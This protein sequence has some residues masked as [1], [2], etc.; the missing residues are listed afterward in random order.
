[1]TTAGFEC[2]N[3]GDP[4]EAARNPEVRQHNSLMRSLRIAERGYWPA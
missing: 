3:G 4:V 2:V 1:M